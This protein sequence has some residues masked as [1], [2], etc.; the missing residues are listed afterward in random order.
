MNMGL[1]VSHCLF[2]LNARACFP[3][4]ILMILEVC[5]LVVCFLFIC[6]FV[7]LF[8]VRLEGNTCNVIFSIKVFIRTVSNWVK[9]YFLFCLNFKKKL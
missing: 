7:S 4:V 1:S 2:I 5:L 6:L 9:Q 8:L 3:C